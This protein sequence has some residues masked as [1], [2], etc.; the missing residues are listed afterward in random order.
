VGPIAM[1]APRFTQ[2]Y[3]GSCSTLTILLYLFH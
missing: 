3:A 1:S 2:V